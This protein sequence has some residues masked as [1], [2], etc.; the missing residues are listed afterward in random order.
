MFLPV[1][2]RYQIAAQ[3]TFQPRCRPRSLQEACTV[4]AWP[5][6]ERRCAQLTP[7]MHRS[8]C[9]MNNF[10]PTQRAFRMTNLMREASSLLRHLIPRAKGHRKWLSSVTPSSSIKSSRVT[11]LLIHDTTAGCQRD[12]SAIEKELLRHLDTHNRRDSR[13]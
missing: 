2:L 4:D 13:F 5:G 6:S 1:Q 11:P 9:T 7:P 10:L 12:L 3:R 8:K